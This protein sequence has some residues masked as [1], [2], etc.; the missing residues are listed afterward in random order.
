M[1]FL[2]AT[3]ETPLSATPCNVTIQCLTGFQGICFWKI[4]V[5]APGCQKSKSPKGRIPAECSGTSSFCWKP[6]AAWSSWPTGFGRFPS[7]FRNI[8]TLSTIMHHCCLPW[9]EFYSYLNQSNAR[10]CELSFEDWH[11]NITPLDWI[12]DQLTLPW[13]GPTESSFGEN[14]GLAGEASPHPPHN[15]PP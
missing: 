1:M 12:G 10:I 5:R 14:Q 6:P 11:S 9:L 7:S 3:T 4:I 8:S 15:P 13:D 2:V